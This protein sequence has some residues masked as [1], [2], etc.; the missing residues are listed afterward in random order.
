MLTNDSAVR[1]AAVME[2]VLEQ[3]SRRAQC[4]LPDCIPI[5]TADRLGPAG[6][7]RAEDVDSCRER[8]RWAEWHG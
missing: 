5:W 6:Q 7:T 4:W 2:A 1:Q 8:I 3:Y